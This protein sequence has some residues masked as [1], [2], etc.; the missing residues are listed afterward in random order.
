MGNFALPAANARTGSLASNAG[1]ANAFTGRAGDAATRATAEAAAR[2][3]RALPGAN[4]ASAPL[5]ELLGRLL[6]ARE[7]AYLTKQPNSTA[8]PFGGFMQWLA[9]FFANEWAPSHGP[10]S[11]FAWLGT[12]LRSRSSCRRSTST[13]WGVPTRIIC[14]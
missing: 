14:L 12:T 8:L 2:A 1:N 5:H 6:P 9:D 11:A 7:R 4:A 13:P 3:F 10:R